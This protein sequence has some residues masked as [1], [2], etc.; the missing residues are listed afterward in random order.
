MSLIRILLIII[1]ILLGIIYLPAI[2][3]EWLANIGLINN[4]QSSLNDTSGLINQYQQI[5]ESHK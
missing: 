4:V 3:Q 5:L 1:P 2:L